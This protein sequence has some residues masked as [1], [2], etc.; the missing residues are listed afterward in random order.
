MV[1]L[2]ILRTEEM[3]LVSVDVIVFDVVTKVVVVTSGADDVAD[4]D[5]L[6][7]VTEE[8]VV[9]TPG[10]DDVA[11]KDWLPAVTEEVVVATP[12]ADDVADKDWLPAVTE[13]VVVATPGA[14]D[15]ADELRLCVVTDTEVVAGAPGTDNDALMPRVV[16]V[17]ELVVDGMDAGLFSLK[18]ISSFN[19]I[20]LFNVPTP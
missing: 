13:E 4:E 16:V 3:G 20:I 8:F 11:D 1:D 7:A 6:P 15:V 5:W 2:V 9:A 19:D 12:G 18:I 17:V 10:A 14:D